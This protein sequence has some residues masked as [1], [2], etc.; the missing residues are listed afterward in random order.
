MRASR[1]PFEL[2]TSGDII[3]FAGEEAWPRFTMNATPIEIAN[4]VAYLYYQVMITAV[5]DAA[6]AN[7][8]QIAEIELIGRPGPDRRVLRRLRRPAVGTECR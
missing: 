3:D 8:M 7:S 5:R 4:D 6:S 1:G 2:I